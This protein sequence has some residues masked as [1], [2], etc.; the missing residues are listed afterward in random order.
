M[1]KKLTVN[2]QYFHLC[3]S[4]FLIYK[5]D[6]EKLLPKLVPGTVKYKLN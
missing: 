5:I 2:W 1:T 6:Y 3:N 4:W